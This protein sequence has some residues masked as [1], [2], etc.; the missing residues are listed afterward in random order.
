MK[1]LKLISTLLVVA[2]LA[3]MAFALVPASAAEIT[4]DEGWYTRE[5][6]DSDPTVLEIDNAAELLAFAAKLNDGHTYKGETVKL[7]TNITLNAGL[8]AK[9]IDPY[10]D[11]DDTPAVVWPV[12][13]GMTKAFNGTFD[14]QGYVL[15][16]IYQGTKDA[17]VGLFGNV[18]KGCEP[19]IK[20]VVITDSIIIGNG[21]G[22]GTLFGEIADPAYLL[23]DELY[24]SKT[25]ATV[26]NV[27]LDTVVVN[28][29]MGG[30]TNMGTGGFVG[31]TRSILNVKNSAF[32][33]TV[34]GGVRGV[35]AVAG[36]SRSLETK[37]MADGTTAADNVW[38]T[39]SEINLENCYLAG[40]LVGC[41]STF[42][43]SGPGFQSFVGG[44]VGYM[45]N[46]GDHVRATNVICNNTFG[47]RIPNPTSV[48]VNKV[49]S[50]KDPYEDPV[51]K[52]K[53]ESHTRK[54]LYTTGY[55]YGGAW[56]AS[57][58]NA[59]HTEKNA[60]QTWTMNDVYYVKT[61]DK[62]SNDFI[63]CQWPVA[64]TVAA[65]QWTLNGTAVDLTYTSDDSNLGSDGKPTTTAPLYDLEG[66]KVTN[67][68]GS[69]VYATTNQSPVNQLMA[70]AWE[71]Y[72]LEKT[73]VDTAD[74][75]N[76]FLT[77]HSWTSTWQVYNNMPLPT[78][79]VNMLDTNE[80]ADVAKTTPAADANWYT[81]ENNRANNTF[82]IYN[83]DDL[84]AFAA[85]LNKGTS[86]AGKTVVLMNNITVDAMAWSV[87][88]S[89]D[90]TFDG[91]G[92]IISGLN[93]TTSFFGNV[94]ASKTATVKNLKITDSALNGLFA[95][96]SG[97]ATVEGVWMD[98]TAAKAAVAETVASGASLT[99]TTSILG[100]TLGTAVVAD[101][102]TGTVT[103]TDVLN[104]SNKTA[105]CATGTVATT[106]FLSK[107][108]S[109]ANA[110]D[111]WT[112]LGSYALPTTVYNYF[113]NGLVGQSLTL[114]DTIALNIY[115]KL[116]SQIPV[117]GTFGEDEVASVVVGGGLHKFSLTGLQAKEMV[118]EVT[119]TYGSYT[120]TTSVKAYCVELMKSDAALASA[121]L[122][123]GDAAQTLAGYKTETMATAGVTGLTAET[124]ATAGL[125]NN[126]TRTGTASE[127]F[128]IDSIGLEIRD[129][130]LILNVKMRFKDL[131]QTQCLR[132][133]TGDKE[134]I[135]LTFKNIAEVED[136]NRMYTVVFYDF[137]FSNMSDVMTFV[138]KVKPLETAEDLGQTYS[139]D[140]EDIIADFM[141]SDASDAEKA[142]VKAM[143]AVSVALAD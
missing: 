63:K 23:A 82:N 134:A 108:E 93:A 129:S 61:S 62:T 31:G 59:T 45:N 64:W 87:T 5:T 10:D 29:S 96:V 17:D 126:A 3:S 85:E 143:Y 1:K 120:V 91:N 34:Y 110:G 70:A 66:N 15:S 42:Y 19:T 49:T 43:T 26:E 135:F 60:V 56:G 4:A 68:A 81:N 65:S 44:I 97:T 140:M 98:V 92:K 24:G 139:T 16:G 103:V 95:T 2:M 6:T 111:A 28:L 27:Y 113:Y 125:T 76:E 21:Q 54:V 22:I 100:G 128:L 115:V 74:E 51:W 72:S 127:D 41:N 57:G 107:S 121:L 9:S 83:A 109:V 8:N 136:E 141:A 86:F 75:W 116:D 37:V 20:N 104:D 18:A 35:G 123:W 132:A 11:V 32:V 79:L 13:G 124:D 73:D 90:G 25:V 14:G 50:E 78:A 117:V 40:H 38:V 118:D 89:F 58:W 112:A 36:Q 133:Q 71:P 46:A 106:R 88:G 142:F 119:F 102:A 122:R 131:S 47:T 114:T 30:N 130:R 67:A 105:A 55:I 138:Q 94:A 69:Q 12:S 80:A 7:T 53:G 99:V 137:D 39:R 48:T 77:D 33:G 52:Y 101:A 84:L